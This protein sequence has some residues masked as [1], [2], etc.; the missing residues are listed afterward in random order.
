MTM[1]A[2]GDRERETLAA[3]AAEWFVANREPLDAAQKA[4]FGEW[5]RR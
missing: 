4:A 5:L 1:G 2:N 3:Q